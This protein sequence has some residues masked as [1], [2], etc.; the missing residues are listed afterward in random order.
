MYSNILS[1]Q[2][3]PDICNFYMKMILQEMKHKVNLVSE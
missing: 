2:Q 1:N 3:Y